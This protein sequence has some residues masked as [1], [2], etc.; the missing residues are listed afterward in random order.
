MS[1]F[2]N[3]LMAWMTSHESQARTEYARILLPIAIFAV[4]VLWLVGRVVGDIN[5]VTLSL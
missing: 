1:A 3:R 4:I 5:A 2:L